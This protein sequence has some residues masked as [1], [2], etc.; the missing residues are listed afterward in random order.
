MDRHPELTGKIVIPHIDRPFDSAREV[1]RIAKK[2]LLAVQ[3]AGKIYRHIV[4]TKARP[5]S[6][7]KF[8]WMK[9]TAP[10]RRRSC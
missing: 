7:R 4:R 10:R 2:F 6:S 8:P 9:R 1:E 5:I 3:D